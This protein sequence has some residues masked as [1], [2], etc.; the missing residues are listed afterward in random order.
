MMGLGNFAGRSQQQQPGVGL[1]AMQ[2]AMLQR[3]RHHMAG[4]GIAGAGRTNIPAGDLATQSITRNLL[5]NN[6]YYQPGPSIPGMRPTQVEK[7]S[8]AEQQLHNKAPTEF[9]APIAGLLN[10]DV[11]GRTDQHPITVAS[12]SYVVPADVVSGLGQGNTMAGAKLLEQIIGAPHMATGGQVGPTGQ[13]IPIVA[14][15]GEYVIPPHRVKAIGGGNLT[16]GHKVL[17]NMVRQVRTA[18]AK[19]MMS[20]PGPRKD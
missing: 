17:D 9:G 18:A 13:P 16:S 11:P 4:G 6:F 2:Q 10:S 5:P 3:H 15:G 12:G 19:R 14:A 1:A 7:P 20:L 8:P